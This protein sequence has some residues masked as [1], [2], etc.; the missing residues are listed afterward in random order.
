MDGYFVVILYHINS[1]LPG[2]RL[3]PKPSAF[4]TQQSA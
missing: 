4:S 1:H 2:L 3:T